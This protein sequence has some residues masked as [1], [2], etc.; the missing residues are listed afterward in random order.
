MS[1]HTQSKFLA[2][3]N[4]HTHDVQPFAR[5]SGRSRDYDLFALD[6]LNEPGYGDDR[7]FAYPV[8]AAVGYRR[9]L[10]LIEL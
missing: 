9:E 3:T 1:F 5:S 8:A 7:I 2:T 6:S 10:V 4:C